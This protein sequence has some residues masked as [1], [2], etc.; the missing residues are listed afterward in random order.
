[1]KTRISRVLAVTASTALVLGFASL[2]AAAGEAD[3]HKSEHEH[4]HGDDGH[5]NEHAH[6][7]GD[8]GHANEHE[9]H[10]AAADADSAHEHHDD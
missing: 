8:D 2:P 5:A 10:H 4:H 1:M 9:H 7:H 6:H 3:M